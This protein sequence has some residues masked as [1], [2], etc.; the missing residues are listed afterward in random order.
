M[1]N[2]SDQIHKI[3]EKLEQQRQRLRDLRAQETK[4]IRKDETRRKVLYGAAV[5]AM[6]DK[7]PDEKRRLALNR[8]EE[9]IS[10]PS[11]RTFLDL[12]PLESVSAA[13]K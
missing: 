7:M 4:Q 6:V 12:P 10:R 3:E 8:I 5:L 9:Y 2:Y 1:P 11:D 13:T